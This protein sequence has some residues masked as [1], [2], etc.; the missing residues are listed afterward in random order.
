MASIVLSVCIVLSFSWLVG[1]NIKVGKGAYS[2]SPGHGAYSQAVPQWPHAL[3]FL[4][5]VVLEVL[6]MFHGLTFHCAS[7][8]NGFCNSAK[9]FPIIS[10]CLSGVA[11]HFV[12][13]AV[14]A[15]HFDLNKTGWHQYIPCNVSFFKRLNFHHVPFIVGLHRAALTRILSFIHTKL[16]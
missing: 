6:M 12:K 14:I 3:D 10:S 4:G 9:R 16:C 15:A 2:Q 13:V 1:Q 5:R 11:A 7:A 8:T